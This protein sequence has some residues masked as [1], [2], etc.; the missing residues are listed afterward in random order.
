MNCRNFGKKV[1]YVCE[2]PCQWKIYASP[3]HKGSAT[4]QIKTYVR[5]HS[6]MPTFYQKQ[7]NSK[8]LADYYETE[9]R[10]NP[11]WPI[12]AFHK[13][14]VNDLKCHV[15]KHAVYRAK[16]RALKKING[17]HEE[18]YADLWKYGHEWKK[19]LPES[20]VKILTENPEPDQISGRFLRFYLCLG[21]L[22][23]AFKNHCRKIVGLDRCHLK[24]PFGGILLS[25]IGVDPNDDVYPVA[26]GLINDLEAIV[27]QAEH[28]FC[29]MHLFQNM[30][31]EYKGL[32]LR[33]LLW[34]AARATT[35]WGFNLHMN[36]MKEVSPN[37]YDWLMQKP[38]EQWSRSAFRTTSHSDMF[39]NNH[40]EVFNNSL[41][42]LRDLPIITLYRELHKTIMKRIQIR[43]DK[44]ANANVII[45]PSAQKKLTKSIHYA[46][47]CVVT[48]S[49]GSAY[50]VTC[51]DGGHEL[52]YGNT[53]E[54]IVGPELWEETPEP[55][56]LP[57][58]VKIPTGR[59]KKKRNKKNDVP[60]DTTK[61]NRTNTK[62]HCTYC[63]AAGH[64]QRSCTAKQKGETFQLEN[65]KLGERNAIQ[66]P[67]K[68]RKLHLIGLGQKLDE[69][70]STSQAAQQD[71]NNGQ[72]T[73]QDPIDGDAQRPK[74]KRVSQKTDAGGK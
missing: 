36:Q 65:P 62:V 73:Q 49:G 67:A 61:L 9:I 31:K 12:S 18:Q 25:A 51:T 34:K 57:P 20:T 27:P 41:S 39:V 33:H 6:C 59:P 50:S 40:C 8:W 71:P 53:L 69:S 38:R 11:S 42:K 44:M 46:G 21:P 52:L 47:N 45:C 32:A 37:C 30:H 35:M 48:W 13:K 26:W 56:P 7:I 1:Q 16:V 23:K 5:K 43:R 4:Y 55:K 14:I 54:P 24:G 19:V 3:L 70:A 60:A 64:N 17:T 15:S 74:R 2:P 72:V 58:A 22:K 28:R 68:S 63:K 66:G 10:M 29:V